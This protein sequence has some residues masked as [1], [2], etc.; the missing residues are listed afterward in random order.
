MEPRNSLQAG[1]EAVS[2]PR[3]PTL[4]CC[5]VVNARVYCPA[6]DP[7]CGSL[8]RDEGGQ[9]G[10]SQ[11]MLQGHTGAAVLQCIRVSMSVY[12]GFSLTVLVLAIQLAEGMDRHGR[13]A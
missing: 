13:F 4:G 1:R 3:F 2:A 8:P 7:P 10:L 6:C 11:E 9:A 5:S 12:A